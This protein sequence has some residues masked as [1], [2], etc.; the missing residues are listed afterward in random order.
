MNKE[1]PLIVVCAGGMAREVIW[2][3]RETREWNPVGFLVDPE[4]VLEKEMCG[5]PYLG[6]VEDWARFPDASFVVAIGSPRLRKGIVKRM[7]GLGE[8][9]FATLIH[10]SVQMSSYVAI[11]EGAMITAGGILTTQI[12]TGRHSLVN[13]GC[14]VGHDVIIGDFCTLSPQVVVSG[15]VTLGDGVEIGTGATLIEKL[16]VGT[17]S[18]IG[19]G[20]VLTKSLPDNALAVGNPARQI[21]TLEPF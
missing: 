5:I 7:E 13:L 14:T 10:P 17:G 15:N 2:L 12:K 11:G 19:A 8:P 9:C 6:G 21:K 18:F 3:A 16:S 20:S 4:Y 1:K